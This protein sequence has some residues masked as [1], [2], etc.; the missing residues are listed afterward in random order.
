VTEEGVKMTVD[1][2]RDG[3]TTVKYADE[4]LLVID[5]ASA[6]LFE[7]HTMDFNETTRQLVFA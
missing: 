1:Q 7:G 2:E 6:P 5:A 3:D 4:V